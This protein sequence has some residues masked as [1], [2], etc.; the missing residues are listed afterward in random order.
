MRE[1]T[2]FDGL[3]RQLAKDGYRT[4]RNHEEL[5]ADFL[6]PYF[7]T[8]GATLFGVGMHLPQATASKMFVEFLRVDIL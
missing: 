4:R 2:S 7:A 1:G 6:A 5:S 3:V 8:R